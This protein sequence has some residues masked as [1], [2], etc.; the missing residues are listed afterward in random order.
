MSKIYLRFIF[1][2]GFVSKLKINKY[3]NMSSNAHFSKNKNTYINDSLV[4]R[5]KFIMIVCIFFNMCSIWL[6]LFLECMQIL[7]NKSLNVS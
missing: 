1:Y 5:Y 6:Y 7:F 2:I 3:L 4:Y